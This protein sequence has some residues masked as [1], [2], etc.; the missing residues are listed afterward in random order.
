MFGSILK[1]TISSFQK[2]MTFCRSICSFIGCG[3][4]LTMFEPPNMDCLAENLICEQQR[5]TSL[6]VNACIAFLQD[7]T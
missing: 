2:G 6:L 4:Y 3:F 1:A 7:F 5:H